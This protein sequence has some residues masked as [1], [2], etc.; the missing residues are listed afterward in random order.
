LRLESYYEADIMNVSKLVKSF[1]SHSDPRGGADLRYCVVVSQTP[2]YTARPW[3]LG[4]C[5]V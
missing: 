3:R 4:W 5:I 1:L 2:C